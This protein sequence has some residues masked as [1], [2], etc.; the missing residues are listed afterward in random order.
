M[1]WRKYMKKVLFLPIGV[2]L[3]HVGRL[4]QVAK[5]LRKL[6]VKV[7]FGA[8]GDAVDILTREKLLF[9]KISEFSRKDYDNKIKKNNFFIYDRHN[10]I[11]FVEDELRLYQQVKPDLIVF[12]TRLTAKISS[13]MAKIPSVSVGNV[14]MTGYY[15]YDKVDLPLH[16][17]LGRYIPSKYL[18]YLRK[19]YGQQFLKNVSKRAIQLMLLIA[20]IRVTPAL[21]QLGFKPVKDPWEFLLGDL[22][23]LTDIPEFRPVKKLPEKVKLVGPIFWDGCGKIPSWSK[24]IEKKE[25]VIYVS[26]SGTGDKILF[27]KILKF[28]KGTEY[29]VVATTGNTL[30]PNEVRVHNNN[31]FVTDFLPGRYIMEKAKLI[32]FPGGNATCYQAL[33]YGVPQITTP[34]HIDQEDNAN[35]LG[36]LGTGIIVNPFKDFNRTTL[37]KGIEKI[38]TDNSFRRNALKYK[39]ILSKYNG[40]GKAAREI[41]K[42]L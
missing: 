14:D 27:L 19:E 33:T 8:G 35:Q 37:I 4:I 38:L 17:T 28:L 2:G 42:L 10:F 13:N 40:A 31:I 24:K 5:E 12:D 11:Q 6:K 25:N 18:S 1:I 36:R 32:I 20:M 16:T 41:K 30:N 29:T 15:D 23:L 39:I 34:F 9:I 21:L 3:A 22:A 7:I 26:A